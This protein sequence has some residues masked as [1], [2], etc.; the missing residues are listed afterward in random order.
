MR[1][2]IDQVIGIFTELGSGEDPGLRLSM[3]T[4]T[5]DT[6]WEKVLRRTS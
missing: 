2:Y 5:F 6:W 4:Q 3:H 1:L